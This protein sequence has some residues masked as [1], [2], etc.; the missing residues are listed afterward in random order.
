MALMR[1][2]KTRGRRVKTRSRKGRRSVRKTRRQ[3]KSQRKTHRRHNKQRGGS[4]ISDT[5]KIP[6]EAIYTGYDPDVEGMFTTEVRSNFKKALDD[7]S[8]DTLSAQGV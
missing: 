4:F 2:M 8:M 1:H 6:D 3:H 5:Q 7:D